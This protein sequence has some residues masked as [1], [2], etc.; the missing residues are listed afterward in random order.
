[1][2]MRVGAQILSPGMNDGYHARFGMQLCVRELSYRFPC[3]GKQQVVKNYRMLKKQAVEFIRNR[4]N[5]MKVWNGK[6]ILLTVFHPCFSPS[7][8]ALWTMTVTAGV[9]TD[10]DMPALITFVNMSAQ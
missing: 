6:Q 5:H 10:A 3:A 1:M 8:L 7:I 9:V 4:K 2:H